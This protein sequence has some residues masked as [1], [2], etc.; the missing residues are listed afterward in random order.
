MTLLTICKKV[1]AET[2]WP[3]FATIASNTDGTAQQIFTIANTELQSISMGFNWPQLETEYDFNTVIGQSTY[4]LPADFQ[5][6]ESNSA[7]DATQFYPVRGSIGIQEWNLRRDEL[8]ANLRCTAFR[9]IYVGGVAGI[10]LTPTPDD[11]RSLV[12]S[13]YSNAYARDSN[14]NNI[15]EFVA[16]SDNPKVPEAQVTLGVKWRFRRMK[17]LDYSAELSE[18]NAMLPTRFAK[19][20]SAPDIAV[21]GRPLRADYTGVT[22]G[23]V[24]ENGFGS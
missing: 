1:L 4:L 18:Y 15:P 21:G 7:Y 13:Y 11:V 24:R 10:R 17:G 2:G 22:N 3:P 20:V 23:Y 12:I 5:S 19:T 8:L 14:G 16:D 9:V 6:L